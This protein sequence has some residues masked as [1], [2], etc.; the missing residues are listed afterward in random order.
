MRLGSQLI[1]NVSQPYVLSVPVSSP[2]RGYSF[3]S[4][5]QKLGLCLSVG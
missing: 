1:L 4:H 2:Y 3:T 5:E